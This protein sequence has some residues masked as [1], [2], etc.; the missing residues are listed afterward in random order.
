[1]ASGSEADRLSEEEREQYRIVAE[2]EE[3]DV[4]WNLHAFLQQA[5]SFKRLVTNWYNP[6]ALPANLPFWAVVD[7]E[8]VDWEARQEQDIHKENGPTEI[9]LAKAVLA[10][11]PALVE[12]AL[13][14]GR[15]LTRA[16]L[17]LMLRAGHGGEEDVFVPFQKWVAADSSL[18]DQLLDRFTRH[19][20]EQAEHGRGPG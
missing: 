18:I 4:D 20:R 10:L 14:L 12:A 3:E 17:Q 2:A 5:P 15:Q 6:L 11:K 9:L 1:M 13:S 19:C 8:M 16:D 7:V